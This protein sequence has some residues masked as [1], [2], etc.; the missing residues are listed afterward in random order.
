MNYDLPRSSLVPKSLA[1]MPSVPG[2][3]LAA[4]NAEITGDHQDTMLA[5][6]E[7]NA[8]VAGVFTRSRTP[9]APVSWCN[10]IVGSGTARALIVNSGN[11]NAFTGYVGTRNVAATTA[12]VSRAIGCRANEVFVASTGVIGEQLPVEK[13]LKAIPTLVKSLA[14]N[15]WLE[16]AEAIRTTDT[17]PKMYTTTYT[18]DGNTYTLNGI[19]KGSGMIFPD[20]G[21]MLAFLFTDANIPSE[22]L[23]SYLRRM[24]RVTFNA[25][26]VDSDTSTSD[27]ALL[28]ATGQGTLH[29]PLLRK[30]DKRLKNFSLA[31]KMV[32][33]NLAHQIVRDGEGAKKFI[34]VNV[35][36]ASSRKAAKNIA[37][38][39]ANSPLVK[40][41]IA[42]EDP[43]WGRIVM[44]VGKAGERA[45]RDKL[46]IIIGDTVVAENGTAKKNYDQELL[47]RHMKNNEIYIGVDVG[48]GKSSF[49]VWTCD[50]TEAY[51]HI[52]SDYRS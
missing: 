14:A 27:T 13:I 46:K 12:A 33:R 16:A 42:G 34:T 17:F 22:I 38:S 45:E 8:Q 47:I 11:A 25:I 18:L 26:T 30:G 15:N 48:V 3:T 49:T 37:A 24:N 7:N 2:V 1:A 23:S 50:L 28:F 10:S 9:S 44:A 40:T 5:Q 31:L 52:N 6:F 35:S 51:V 19:A 43:N 36:G 21:T 39:I 29:R 4:I 20:M 41:A 32:M